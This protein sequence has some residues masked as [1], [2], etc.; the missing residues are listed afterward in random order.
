M[1]SNRSAL[2]IKLNKFAIKNLT[3]N[4]VTNVCIYYVLLILHQNFRSCHYSAWTKVFFFFFFFLNLPKIMDKTLFV[5]NWVKKHLCLLKGNRFFTT[6]RQ[7]VDRNWPYCLW[8][9]FPDTQCTRLPLYKCCSRREGCRNYHYLSWTDSC[10]HCPLHCIL[11]C[12]S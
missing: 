12:P 9:N 5:T 10:P 6:N 2:W 11:L 7:I 1:F 3:C 8:G 4:D